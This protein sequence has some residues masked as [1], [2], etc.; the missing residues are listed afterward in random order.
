MPL[1]HPPWGRSEAPYPVEMRRD[2]YASADIRPEPNGHAAGRYQSTIPTGAASTRPFL[3]VWIPSNSPYVVLTV[4]GEASLGHIRPNEDYGT[5]FSY[6]SQ[7]RSIFNLDVVC[8]EL[9]PG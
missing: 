5:G 6:Q 7:D 2:P 3:I 4:H 8:H 1:W 9:A